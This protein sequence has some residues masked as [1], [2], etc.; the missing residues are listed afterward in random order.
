MAKYDAS[1]LYHLLYFIFL[2]RYRYLMVTR[3]TQRFIEGL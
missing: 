2:M 3:E 1:N